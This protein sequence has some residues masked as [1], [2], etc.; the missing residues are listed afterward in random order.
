MTKHNL[1]PIDPIPPIR[2]GWKTTEF[3]VAIATQIAAF[4]GFMGWITP[5]MQ[6]EMPLFVGQ[7]AMGVI[8]MA[9]IIMYIWSRTQVKKPPILPPPPK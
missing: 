4:L 7:I 3:W 1:K 9:A 5:D 8:G 6:Q 2:P